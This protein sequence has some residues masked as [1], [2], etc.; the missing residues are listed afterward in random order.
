MPKNEIVRCWLLYS[1]F[2]SQHDVIGQN[3]GYD[4]DKIKRF[5]F[6]VRGLQ[7]DTMY[8][9]FAINPELPKGLAFN[10]SIFTEEPYYKDE[11]IYEGSLDDLMIGCGKDCCVTKEIDDAMQSDIDEMHLNDYYRNFLLPL[12][13]LYA[14]N[15]LISTSSPV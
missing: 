4:R 3:F 7:D 15:K 1:N 12:H 14:F 8:K 2:L 11:G 9:S 6:T 10:T 13:D 5:G